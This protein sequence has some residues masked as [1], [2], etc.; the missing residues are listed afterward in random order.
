MIFL[1]LNY[2]KAKEGQRKNNN[3]HRHI[4]FVLLAASITFFEG[5]RSLHGRDSASRTD[6]CQ[7]CGRSAVYM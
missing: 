7:F 4:T 6:G 3:C 2:L 1:E 5:A